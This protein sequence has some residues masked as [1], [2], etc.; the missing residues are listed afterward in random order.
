MLKYYQNAGAKVVFDLT[1]HLP[2]IKG[3]GHCETLTHM[4]GRSSLVILPKMNI[5][6]SRTRFPNI[7]WPPGLHRKNGLGVKTIEE[8]A[9]E[10]VC[11]Q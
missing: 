6:R 2:H 3:V 1:G 10:L 8:R 7:Q 11:L 9:S 5:S 4:D